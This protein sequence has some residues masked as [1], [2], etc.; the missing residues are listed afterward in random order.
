LQSIAQI[1]PVSL[2]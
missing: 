2:K 1:S